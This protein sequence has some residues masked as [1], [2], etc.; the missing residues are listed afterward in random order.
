MKKQNSIIKSLFTLLLFFAVLFTGCKDILNNDNNSDEMATLSISLNEADSRNVKP[1]Y[2][3]TSFTNFKL[4]GTT[5]GSNP[6]TIKEWTSYSSLQSENVSVFP[7]NWTF[8]LTAK[9]GT[10]DFT[11][12]STVN[13]TAGSNVQLS[14]V[15]THDQSSAN[16]SLRINLSYP[17]NTCVSRVMFAIAEMNDTP[18]EIITLT[19][20][21]LADN[22][23]NYS[24]ENLTPGKYYLEMGFYD[25][26]YDS[27]KSS[28]YNE[29]AL[30]T[31]YYEIIEIEA[32][33]ETV[34]EDTINFIMHRGIASARAVTSQNGSTT[35]GG[36]EFKIY[37]PKGTQNV[38]LLRKNGDYE[39]E[40]ANRFCYYS[41]NKI[42]T[43]YDVFG[44]TAG[45]EYEYKVRYDWIWNNSS[46]EFTTKLTAIADSMKSPVLSSYPS[47][48]HNDNEVS[49]L[50]LGTAPVV[51]FYN[52][53]ISQSPSVK[54]Y[55]QYR[56]EADPDNYNDGKHIEV[57]YDFKTQQ[58][59]FNRGNF[60]ILAGTT[61]TLCVARI[62]IAINGGTQ[63]QIFQLHDGNAK[64]KSDGV[65]ETI[66]FPAQH[67]DYYHD[68]A[69]SFA[70]VIPAGT[71]SVSI[72]RSEWESNGYG[73]F[74]KVGGKNYTEPLASNVSE[75]FYDYYIEKTKCYQYKVVFYD[76]SE[77][78]TYST[79]RDEEP[80]FYSNY[81][82]T[83]SADANY[84][85]FT[86]PSFSE[87]PEITFSKDET[88]G[89]FT[90]ELTKDPVINWY[91][92]ENP[93]AFWTIDF[94]Y[95]NDDGEYFNWFNS[96]TNGKVKTDS[97]DKLNNKNYEICEFYIYYNT[98]GDYFNSY[99]Y[100]SS[101]EVKAIYIAGAIPGFIQK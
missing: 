84:Q 37:V 49:P 83:F 59:S 88:E 1:V 78:A 46:Y 80:F 52:D 41:E 65:P 27:S 95:A 8:T 86:R 87:N 30:V 55:M 63:T 20:D 25:A 69:I 39:D 82:C 56:D 42:I 93:N 50:N 38:S 23:I 29:N 98:R 45:T 85:G 28:S 70:V 9:K 7:G 10:E 6:E 51:T 81:V 2:D 26:N 77:N 60:A 97:L 13:I 61:R 58:L 12:T 18:A 68:K 94:R 34:L 40:I 43:L 33:L 64:M 3:F 62:E 79:F 71:K 90:L 24:H 96:D 19:G 36:M 31:S 76:N 22:K 35:F 44:L 67:V 15:M 75:V 73:N 16:G 66:S 47:F 48:T 92:F 53:E 11:G 74:V 91:G 14:F 17:A 21:D 89:T 100:F 57:I 5:T 101:E 32:G 72:L 99:R 54:L 4:T